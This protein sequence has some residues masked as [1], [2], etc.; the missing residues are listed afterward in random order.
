M[1]YDAFQNVPINLEDIEEEEVVEVKRSKKNYAECWQHMIRKKVGVE[2][3]VD[4]WKACCN[5]CGKKLS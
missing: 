4:I 5:Y 3:E 1:G 2:N